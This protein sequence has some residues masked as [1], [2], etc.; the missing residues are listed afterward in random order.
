[1]KR[2][3][4]S[5]GKMKEIVGEDRRVDIRR[6]LGDKQEAERHASWAFYQV[7]YL[8]GKLIKRLRKMCSFAWR[9]V[10]FVVAWEEFLGR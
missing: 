4:N 9:S 8:V 10:G 1:M 2:E 5:S 6:G 3:S 7:P